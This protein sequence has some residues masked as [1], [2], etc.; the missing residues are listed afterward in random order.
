MRDTAPGR[1]YNIGGGNRT[2]LRC[3][4]EVLAGLAGRPLDVRHPSASPA[5]CWTPAPTRRAP[6]ASSASR[7]RTTLEDGLAAE[8]DWVRERD[9]P[10]PRVHSLTAS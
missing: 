5:T 6:R 7:P 2:S 3:A 1:V 8:L 10:A 4:L 9:E